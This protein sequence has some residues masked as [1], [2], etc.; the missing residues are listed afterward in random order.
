MTS[1][2]KLKWTA[3]IRL[4]EKTKLKQMP[5]DHLTMSTSNMRPHQPN[6]ASKLKICSIEN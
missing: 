2:G 1:L 4:Q 3:M 5:S 6:A